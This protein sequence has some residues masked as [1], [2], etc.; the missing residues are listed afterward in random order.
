MKKY[1]LIAG[2]NGAGKSTVLNN[3]NRKANADRIL[4]QY[5]LLKKIEEIGKAHIIGSYRMDMMAWND[6]DIDIENDA[7][8]VDKLY[9]LTTFIVN[10]FHPIWYEAKEEINDDGKKVWFHG[11]ETMIT[12][13][14]W[15]IDL[16]FFDKETIT[17]AE[18]YCDDI[19]KNTSQE[20]KDIIINIKKE[21]LS[22]GLYSFDQY[23]SIDV[24]EA[25]LENN[26]KNIDDFL[27]LFK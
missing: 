2:V 26:V 16:W 1:I 20:Q 21:L 19:K 8:S 9:E 23:K 17:C 15:N 3:T 11:F 22:R 12:G 25:V 27:M 14:L 4:Y 13:E 10:T 18:K 6:L 24:Y 5:G 7:M